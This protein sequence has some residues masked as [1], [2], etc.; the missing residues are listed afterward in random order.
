MQQTSSVDAMSTNRLLT[1]VC[2]LSSTPTNTCLASSVCASSCDQVILKS[3]VGQSTGANE[4]HDFDNSLHSFLHAAVSFY[5]QSL[6]M[7]NAV[8]RKQ[9][10]LSD[11][12]TNILQRPARRPSILGAPSVQIE[13]GLSHVNSFS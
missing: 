10:R 11:S 8:I 6:L 9:V 7:N 1:V 4:I 2:R 12:L 13:T 5:T 3:S